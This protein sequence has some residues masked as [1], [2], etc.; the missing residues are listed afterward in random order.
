MPSQFWLGGYE[1]GAGMV[2]ARGHNPPGWHDVEGER[3]SSSNTTAEQ[4]D[5]SPVNVN[6]MAAAHA[7]V[8]LVVSERDA[9]A[10]FSWLSSGR[11]E[12]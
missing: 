11:R 8:V 12:R 2:V 3:A 4:D 5:G 6:G 10:L 1:I 9:F 7:L